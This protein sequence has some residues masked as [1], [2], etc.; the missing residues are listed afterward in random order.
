M[1]SGTSAISGF[2]GGV[3]V[4]RPVRALL[5]RCAVPDLAA[6]PSLLILDVEPRHAAGRDVARPC[7]KTSV[8]LDET[9]DS[10]LRAIIEADVEGRRRRVGPTR[11]LVA[12]ALAQA[13]IRATG[14]LGLHIPPHTRPPHLHLFE[15]QV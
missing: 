15:G 3:S 12:G 11:R 5:N 8:A 13:A 2:D 9:G 6:S 4:R 10:V 7:V 14:V 1:S